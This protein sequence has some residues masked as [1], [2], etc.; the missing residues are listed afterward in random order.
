MPNLPPKSRDWDASLSTTDSLNL[1]GDGD[2]ESIENYLP[3]NDLLGAIKFYRTKT[4][5]DLA[6]ARCSIDCIIAQMEL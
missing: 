4:G 1:L 2:R 3:F 6:Q 5:V